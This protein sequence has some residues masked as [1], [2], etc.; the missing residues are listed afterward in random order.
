[1]K[2]KYRLGTS[3]YIAPGESFRRRFKI[4][5]VFGIVAVIGLGI[6]LYDFYNKK[7]N[8]QSPTSKTTVKQVTFENKT[9]STP[10]FS[11]K[12][13]EDWKL[14]PNQSTGNKFVF[15]KYLAN[16]DLVQHQLM[17]YVNNTPP[18]LD[19]A[20]SRVLPVELNSGN[21]SFI[22]KEVSDHCGKTYKPGE[23]HRVLPKQVEGS[24]FLCDPEQGQFR[25][26]IAK[27]GGD[28]NLKLKRTDGIVANYIIIY[29]N[30]KIDPDTETIMHIASSFQSL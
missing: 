3:K 2:Q 17:V 11:F 27:E 25:V 16:S 23:L 22:P 4:L 26:I 18:A 19:L 28:Y 7:Q 20:S 30:Q 10:Y 6:F 21:T 9:F 1:M 8:P 15:Q 5:A 29:Q 14:I 12:D 24:T 13:S